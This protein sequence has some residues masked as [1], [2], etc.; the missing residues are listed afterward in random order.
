MEPESR[1]GGTFRA[2]AHKNFRDFCIGQSISLTGT[3]VQITALGWFIWELTGSPAMLGL[4]QFVARIPT[5]FFTPLAGVLADRY[6]RHRIVL[7][8]QCFAMVQALALAALALSGRAEVWS[9]AALALLLGVITA[10]DV[11]ARQSFAIELVGR[12]DLSNAIALNSFLFNFARIVGPPMA[13]GLVFLYS[14]GVCFAVNGLSYTIVIALLLRM[15]MAPRT[16]DLQKG[17]FFQSF[18]E[19]LKF[20]TS[21]HA[22]RDVLLYM[23]LVAMLGYTHAAVLPAVAGDV[24]GREVGGFA[25]LLAASGLGAMVGALFL[26]RYAGALGYPRVI[27]F[28]GVMLG[29]GL[30]VF[31]FSRVF[32]L[33]VVLLFPA[34]AGMMIQSAATNTLLQQLV[35]DR[36]RGRVISLFSTV[37][38]GS[39][40]IGSLILGTLAERIG[41]LVAIRLGGIVCL[42]GGLVL[43]TRLKLIE[44]SV[45]RLRESGREETAERTDRAAGP[46]SSA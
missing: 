23:G 6:S 26:A 41:P 40:P 22:V 21:N 19:G 10:F 46:G 14:E 13:A 15:R 4:I 1:A 17:G 45:R 32:W 12:R 8:T 37:F 7:L 42:G 38:L 36:M 44:A 18:N 25:W 34:G 16:Y 33:S 35:P 28:A 29:I 20:A 11:P 9:V 39:I 43:V 30:V 3:W 24:L 5:L 27:A 31:S 2:L